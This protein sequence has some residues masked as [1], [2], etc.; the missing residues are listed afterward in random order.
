MVN[1]QCHSTTTSRLNARHRSMNS[2]RVE[3]PAAPS[4]PAVGSAEAAFML[5][6][7]VD[8]EA[9][10]LDLPCRVIDTEL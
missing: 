3:P 8:S 2:S 4:A 6:S 9:D 5:V 10:R 7:P 1:T